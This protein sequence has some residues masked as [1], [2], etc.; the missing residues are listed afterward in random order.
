MSDALTSQTASDVV[1]QRLERQLDYYRAQAR[2][3]KR[4]YRSVKL[5]QILIGVVIPVLAA[6][7]AT[8]WVTAAVAAIPIAAE[9]AQQLFQWHSN[10]LRLRAAAEALKTES[11]LFHAEAGPYEAANR[12]GILAERT[13]RISREESAEWFSIHQAEASP[14]PP[15]Q[16]P[17]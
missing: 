7:G 3:N 13:T 16:L 17:S 9:G 14:P 8:G 2:K 12:L 1:L 4:A 10:W 15:S 6:A 5:V 11:F